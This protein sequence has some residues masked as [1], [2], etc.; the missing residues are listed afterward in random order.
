[1]FAYSFTGELDFK[2][3]DRLG[4]FKADGYKAGL[5]AL[6]GCPLYFCLVT[7]VLSFPA[8]FPFLLCLRVVKGIVVGP[9]KQTDVE[10]DNPVVDKRV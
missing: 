10:N 9:Q 5:L 2:L 4:D 8:Y 1:M 3:V 6:F 7:A